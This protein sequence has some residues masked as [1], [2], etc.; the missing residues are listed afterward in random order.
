MKTTTTHNTGAL[1]QQ[2][3]PLSFSKRLKGRFDGVIR[4]KEFQHLTEAVRQRDGWYLLEPLGVYPEHTV[5][6]ETAQTHLNV[7]VQEI[8]HEERGIWSTMVYVQSMEDPW[9][10][11]VFHPRRAGCGCGGG[12]EILPWWI[13]SRIKPEA[14]AAWNPTTC[15]TPK[16]QEERWWKKLW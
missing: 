8:L 13:F 10:I 7:L 12:G 11:K 16:T 1:A 9:I 3:Y 5:D 6:G 15:T 4:Q 14:V 2:S